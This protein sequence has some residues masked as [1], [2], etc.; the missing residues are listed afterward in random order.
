MMIEGR[1]AFAASETN[2]LVTGGT[3]FLGSR[4]VDVFLAEGAYVRCAGHARGGS[5]RAEPQSK[6]GLDYV[7]VDV[8]ERGHLVDATA[9]M[10]LVIHTAA[11]TDASS[12]DERV[13]QEE[14]NVGGT[15]NVLAACR[16]HDVSRLIHVS[17]T[18]AIG[19]SPDPAAPADEKF[20][21]NLEGLDL[22]YHV[23]KRR[24]EEMVLDPH[25]S[26]PSVLVVN[27]GFMF[28]AHR[29][30]YRGSETITRVLDR[31]VVPCTRGGMSVVHVDDVVQGILAAVEKGRPGER[32]ILSG[33]NVSFREIAR[34]VCQVSDTHRSLVPVPDLVRDVAGFIR[35]SLPGVAED[36]FHPHLHG[37]YAYQFYSSDKAKKDLGFDP[38]SFAEI[39]KDYLEHSGRIAS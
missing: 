25:A 5:S 14:I 18:A 8:R 31:R 20:A 19:I 17:S 10:D 29:G 39:V 15:R 35:D 22:G 16:A 28:G 24:A 38:R 2:V 26:T 13:R 27:P 3:G 9:D 12:P 36:G 11:V 23:S 7:E 34:T 4:L 37:H 6:D 1:S 32:Y 21:F 33:D 30:E